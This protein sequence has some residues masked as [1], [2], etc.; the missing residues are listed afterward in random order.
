MKK[1]LFVLCL[2]LVVVGC[3]V[4]QYS[5][6]IYPTTVQFDKANFKYI[7]TIKGAAEA[8]YV[9][10]GW[11]DNKSDG[12]VNEAK[13]NMYEQHPL[14]ENQVPTNI[15]VDILREGA[16]NYQKESM[17]LRKVRV[18]ITADIFEFS[19]DGV[20]SSKTE[21][22]NEKIIDNSSNEE[23][24]EVT[25]K[26]RGCVSGNCD[27]G[28]GTYIWSSGNKYIGEWKSGKMNGV[29]TYYWKNGDKYEGDWVNDYMD[30]NG[31]YTYK[32]GD[33]EKGLFKED[34]LIEEK[35]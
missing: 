33:I 10:G 5:G 9:Y 19:N 30:G 7:K 2:G 32:N 27:D 13:T 3:T 6:E 15:T 8:T 26:L 17:E 29:G 14:K 23:P 28:Q 16:P 35:P 24:N 22:S 25:K 21:Y 12:L 11:D 4:T 1:I 34:D 31:V 18:V 20:Y